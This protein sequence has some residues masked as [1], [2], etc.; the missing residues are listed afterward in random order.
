MKQEI[1]PPKWIRKLIRSLAPEHLQEEI[2]GDLYEFFLC[3]LKSQSPSRARI[4]YTFRALGF[5]TKSFFWN[6]QQSPTN[7]LTMIYMYFRMA[8]RSLKAHK[9]TA[10]I[11]SIGLIVGIASALVIFSVIDFETSFDKFHSQYNQIYRVV[12]VSGED[13]SEFRTGVSYPVPKAIQEGVTGIEAITPMEYIGGVDVDFTNNAGKVIKF[14]EDNGVAAVEPSFFEIFDFKHSEFRWLEG[15]K[16]TALNAPFT[17]VLTERLARKYFGEE[18][19]LGKT[20]KLQKQVDCTVTG[21]VTDL[22]ENTDFPFDM[23][24]SYKTLELLVGDAMSDW[25]SVSD[26]HQ[27]FVVAKAGV[28]QQEIE[29]QI[30]RVHAANTP[31]DFSKRRN[32]LL[33]KLADVHF[34]SRFGNFRG[35]TVSY[36][37]LAALGLI[38]LFILGVACINYINLATAQSIVRSKEIGIRKVAGGSRATL[39]L[40]L[41]AETFL[42]VTSAAI[43]AVV[44]SESVLVNFQSLLNMNYQEFDFLQG[45]KL[46]FLGGTIVM[47]TLLAGIYPSIKASQF[48][49]VSAIQSKFVSET[50]GGLS[51]RKSLVVVQFTITKI[52]VVGAFVVL[53]Q[54]N[55]FNNTD[56]GFNREAIINIPVVDI[57]SGRVQ[58]F[59]E[60]L[61]RNNSVREVSQSSTFPSGV[62]RNRSN[63]DIG[64]REMERKNFIVYEHQGIDSAYVN[65]YGIKILAGR[66]LIITDTSRNILV[67]EELLKN[68]MLGAPEQAL[69]KE[70]ILGD[71]PMT[72]AGVVKNFYSHS[73]KSNIDNI[74]MTYEPKSFSQLS[75]KLEAGS[76]S[77]SMSD[78]LDQIEALWQSKLPEY[79]FSYQFFDENVEAFY[80]QEKK[81]SQL[82]LA[83]AIVFLSI[84]CLGLYGLIAF[85]VNRKQKEVAIRKVLGASVSNIL[86]LFSREY[87][88][89]LLIAMAIATPVSYYYANQWLNSFSNH[90]DLQWWHFVL[91]G[92]LVL[93]MAFSIICGRAFKTAE[94][95][96]ADK[97]KTE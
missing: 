74:V 85:V 4:R 63:R 18:S 7:L 36:E 47:V 66:N 9:G 73:L 64:T 65:L 35:R 59:K 92:V 23:L 14:R 50:I 89:L 21:V 12:R 81:Y 96:P 41:L 10:I 29:E 26:E 40:Q 48:N 22:P 20:I 32:Y 90:I 25:Y 37:L 11:N 95:Q 55:Y 31:P 72:I 57:D 84:G 42:L 8:A 88:Q 24:I 1:Q 45:N 3:D 46:L 76:D 13:K 78:A 61:A 87:M 79:I 70:V 43:I 16:K 91:P 83:F 67:N 80:A 53:L 15:E 19:A 93:L 69:G 82:V 17:I 34:D 30:A 33:Q 27:A 28:A 38:G 54:T 52:L 39:M 51:L 5:L 86:L 75:V 68:L 77:K 44:V 94:A 62:R 60:Q 71:R 56:M 58:S 2:E 6:Q 49:P 97:L